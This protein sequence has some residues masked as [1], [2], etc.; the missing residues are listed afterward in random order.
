M[1]EKEILNQIYDLEQQKLQTDELVSYDGED[2]IVLIDEIRD[3]LA[4]LGDP[5]TFNCGIGGID[6]ITEGVQPGEI[7]VVS[8]PTGQGKTTLCQ[9]FTRSLVTSGV[10]VAWFSYE[11]SYRD[12]IRRFGN[13]LPS[14]AVPRKLIGSRL[15]WLKIKIREAKAKFG[16]QVVFVDHLH[17][18]I[19]M[20]DL[21]KAKST[22]ILIGM[23]MREL[24]EFSVQ[25]DVVIYLISHI[26]KIALEEKPSIDDLRDSSFIG[27]ESD[28][29]MLV[30]RVKED[31]R[32]DTFTNKSKVKIDKN[33]RSGKTG[34]V[35][36]VMGSSGLR[37]EVSAAHKAAV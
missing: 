30:W 12:M 36:L 7:V 37:E 20:N 35:D 23:L 9:A 11:V 27:Q 6:R 16:T 13:N 19:S 4:K 34:V 5:A 17:Y 15:D 33:R 29:V 3:E 31:R 8:G 22:S 28:I 21:A 14:F 25:E 10:N 26:K 24:K 32:S 18:L 2:K 1:N